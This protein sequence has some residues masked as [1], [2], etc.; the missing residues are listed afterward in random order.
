M[1]SRLLT[2]SLLAF[3]VACSNA[4]TDPDED[5]GGP[6]PDAGPE[7]DSGP[8]SD[9]GPGR[10]EHLDPGTYG[11]WGIFPVGADPN[12]VRRDEIL[13]V[14]EQSLELAFDRLDCCYAFA[15][16]RLDC[17]TW[18]IEGRLDATI[19]PTTPGRA[20]LDIG[21]VPRE[22]S[23]VVW[24]DVGAASFDVRITI[25]A[26]PD[27]V[28]LLGRWREVERYDCEG[29]ALPGFDAV[30]EL[31]L[32]PD[33]ALGVTWM[34]FERYV[35]YWGHYEAD[36]TSGAFSISVTGGN[37][38]PTHVDSEG[39]YS[40]EDGR[41]HLRTMSLGSRDESAP[42]TCEHVFERW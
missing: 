12:T 24:A 40:I 27:D 36:R 15:S 38:V 20:L 32:D 35:D 42:G 3:A 39:S 9:A 19:T 13:A 5:G 34:L 22:S 28:A 30:R 8:E 1:R 14:P 33:G 21:A 10:C 18:R 25:P 6:R 31:V 37:I 4:E 29:A 26:E 23:F 11:E 41:L 7:S 2:I 17:V 16:S